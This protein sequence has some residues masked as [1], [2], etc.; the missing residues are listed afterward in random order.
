MIA[1][2]GFVMAS[3][4]FR[5]QASDGTGRELTPHPETHPRRVVQ[6]RCCEA[7][8]VSGARPEPL[9]ALASAKRARDFQA[10][11][12][13]IL[14]SP[15]IPP[16]MDDLPRTPTVLAELDLNA[17]ESSPARIMSTDVML[18]RALASVTRILMQSSQQLQAI[19]IPSLPHAPIFPGPDALCEVLQASR[20]R[21][22]VES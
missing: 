1:V 12:R 8:R 7:N 2:V 10:S 4:G 16:P 9:H 13:D 19:C 3:I 17:S 5:P 14:P 11:A 6:R 18:L 15:N 21:S 20:P 22:V